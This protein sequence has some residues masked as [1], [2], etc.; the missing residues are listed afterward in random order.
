MCSTCM[1]HK[2]HMSMFCNCC[3][4]SCWWWF[5]FV[6]R[7]FP[8]DDMARSDSRMK[9]ESKRI[10]A[11]CLMEI[12]VKSFVWSKCF[13]FFAHGCQWIGHPWL[14]VHVNIVGIVLL[15][16]LNMLMSVEWISLTLLIYGCKFVLVVFHYAI[17]QLLCWPEFIS[18]VMFEDWWILPQKGARSVFGN[19]SWA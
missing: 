18:L 4:F 13:S 1:R 11:K 7:H 5:V 3:F 14:K 6:C 17:D 19:M 15:T 10:Q 9:E 8:D 12:H 16:F 2:L